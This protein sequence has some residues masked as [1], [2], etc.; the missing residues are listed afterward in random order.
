ML[1]LLG[2]LANIAA[3]LPALEDPGAYGAL[4]ALP[5]PNFPQRLLAA[6]LAAVEGL[7]AELQGA[8][9]GMQVGGMT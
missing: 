1:S 4:A 5:A 9:E 8:L 6:Q 7:L 2:T 3:R